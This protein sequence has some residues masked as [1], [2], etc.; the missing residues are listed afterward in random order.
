MA[1]AGARLAAQRAAVAAMFALPKPPAMRAR[2]ARLLPC[3][4]GDPLDGV[5]RR[6]ARPAARVTF[7]GLALDNLLSRTCASARP[8]WRHL[9]RAP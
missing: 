5:R 6:A 1:A 4:P 3:A 2:T 8:A 9:A 7:F